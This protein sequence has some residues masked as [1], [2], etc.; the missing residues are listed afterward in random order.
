[1]LIG[2]AV[3]TDLGVRF[4]FFTVDS[5]DVLL[6]GGVAEWYEAAQ[7]EAEGYALFTFNFST[8]ALIKSKTEVPLLH[9]VHIT[10]M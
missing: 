1:M 6:Q 4:F 5:L 7:R 8:A 3:V 10:E 2:R 9:Y